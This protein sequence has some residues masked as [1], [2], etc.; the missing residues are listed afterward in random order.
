MD[1]NDDGQTTGTGDDFFLCLWLNQFAQ[2]FTFLVGKS[3]FKI[4]G[5]VELS[6]WKILLLFLLHSL[7]LFYK[8]EGKTM[9]GFS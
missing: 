8:C 9:L 4:C 6:E 2:L 1:E 5:D 7:N 3:G